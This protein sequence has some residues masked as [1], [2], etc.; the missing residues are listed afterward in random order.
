MIWEESAY[1]FSYGLLPFFKIFL[2]FNIFTFF[3]LF[4]LVGGYL[5]KEESENRRKLTFCTQAGAK[6]E[7]VRLVW[8]RVFCH[9][10]KSLGHHS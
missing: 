8:G 4:L 5:L 2:F 1:R 7:V 3:H 9:V 6:G 10:L